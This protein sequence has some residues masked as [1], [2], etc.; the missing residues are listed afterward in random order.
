M[1]F[2]CPRSHFWDMLLAEGVGMDS[3]NVKAVTDWPTP[4]TIKEL[5]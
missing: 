5:Q 1:S 2:M 3:D 4:R